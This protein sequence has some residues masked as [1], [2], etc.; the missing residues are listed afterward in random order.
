[1]LAITLACHAYNF[2]NLGIAQVVQSLLV[3]GIRL[4]Q[5]IHHQM[6]MT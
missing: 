5:I 2:T 4:L 3:G 1:M 6:T